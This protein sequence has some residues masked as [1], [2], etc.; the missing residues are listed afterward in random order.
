MVDE[1]QMYAAAIREKAGSA[2][3]VTVRV[4]NN[5]THASIYP[6]ALSAGLRHLGS[7]RAGQE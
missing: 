2:V 7:P 1:L 4:F 3:N 5:E 6:A